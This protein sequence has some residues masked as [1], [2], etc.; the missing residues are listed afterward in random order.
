MGDERDGVMNWPTGHTT[1]L[2]ALGWVVVTA[3]HRYTLLIVQYHRRC[4]FYAM[5]IYRIRCARGNR[6]RAIVRIRNSSA[7]V[8]IRSSA[9]FALTVLVKRNCTVHVAPTKPSS[10]NFEEVLHYEL[11]NSIPTTTS[12]SSS[13]VLSYSVKQRPTVELQ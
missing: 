11:L 12:H 3:T 8:G 1:P 7:V 2:V 9:Y 4:R 13:N 6:V 5:F 10:F